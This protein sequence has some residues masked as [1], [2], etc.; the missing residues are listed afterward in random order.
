M[1]IEKDQLWITKVEERLAAEDTIK[2]EK[3]SSA[4]AES[5]E[6]FESIIYENMIF[7]S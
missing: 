6:S 3:K 4:T 1:A 2:N 7:P 5:T